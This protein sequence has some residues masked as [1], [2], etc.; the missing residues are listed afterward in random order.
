MFSNVTSERVEVDLK[1][2]ERVRESEGER[3]RINSNLTNRGNA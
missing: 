1:Q 3:G 2:F